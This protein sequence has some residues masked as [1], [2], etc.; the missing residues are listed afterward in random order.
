M[1][2]RRSTESGWVRPPPPPLEIYCPGLSGFGLL[3]LQAVICCKVFIRNG[4]TVK[5]FI[6]LGLAAGEK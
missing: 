5:N 3:G 2:S 4:L 6:L 1:G